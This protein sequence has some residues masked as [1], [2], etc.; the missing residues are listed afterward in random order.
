[1]ALASLEERIPPR[2]VFGVAVG[3]LAGFS[4]LAIVRPLASGVFFAPRPHATGYAYTWLVLALFV[5]YGF[6]LWV[7][8]RVP[9]PSIRAVIVAAGIVTVPLMVAPLLQ[10]QDLYQYLFYAKMQLVHGANP[11]I[12]DPDTFARDPWFAYVGWHEQL[13]VYGPL[14]SLAMQGVVAAARGSLARAVLMS[15]T[16]A[17]GFEALAVWGL[18]VLT[19]AQGSDT[20]R[21]AVLVVAAFAMNPLVLSSVALSGHADIAVAAALVWAVVADRRGRHASSAT[22]LAAATLVKAYAA[23]A[24][25]AYLILL[26]RRAGLKRAI[27]ASLPAAALT[28]VACLP[29]WRGATTFRG[30]LAIAGQT[31]ASLAGTAAKILSS[32]LEEADVTRPAALALA[33]VRVAGAAF[34]AAT[35]VR[36]V[37]TGRATRD[38]WP[39]VL[40]LMSAYLL[41]T[42]WF[43]P[44]HALGVFGLACAV[45]ESPLAASDAVFTGSCLATVGGPRLLGPIATA[46]ARYGPPVIVFAV[47][48]RRP[49][50]RVA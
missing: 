50:S 13:S 4:A 12:V 29:Y 14:W 7:L 33:I 31:S 40:T 36:L 46:T 17:V 27:R 47:R 2:V 11:Y 37:R 45:P 32:L 38:P 10:S 5:P 42:P 25:V 22:L 8:R 3:T 24:L 35:F 20:G 28:L 16:L 23:I 26:W 34:F 1:M 19:R 30:M 43:L 21:R 15:K 41:V 49:V 39:S 44:W 48:R 9:H 18:V 6:A